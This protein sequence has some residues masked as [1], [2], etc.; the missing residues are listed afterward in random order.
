MVD[1]DPLGTEHG[2]GIAQA[3]RGLDVAA[4][5]H[6]PPRVFE[7]DDQS[8]SLPGPGLLFPGAGNV[9]LGSGNVTLPGHK[10]AGGVD[11]AD[12]GAERAVSDVDR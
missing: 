1:G 6:G 5:E 12:D 3:G 2:E 4:G 9:T 7:L 11:D 8:A 10:V